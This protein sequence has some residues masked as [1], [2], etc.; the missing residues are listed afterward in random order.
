MSH[1]NHHNGYIFRSHNSNSNSD[2]M[3]ISNDSNLTNKPLPAENNFLND[4]CEEADQLINISSSSKLSNLKE[5]IIRKDYIIRE[6]KKRTCL[7][8]L[9]KDTN[10][11][12]NILDISDTPLSTNVHQLLFGILEI[13]Y[14]RSRFN[15]ELSCQI[16]LDNIFQPTDFVQ[17]PSFF[18]EGE[19]LFFTLWKLY[20]TVDNFFLCYDCGKPSSDN[21]LNYNQNDLDEETLQKYNNIKNRCCS[22]TIEVLLSFACSKDI[23]K[24][25]LKCGICQSII[26]KFLK[27]KCGHIFHR[28]CL[29]EYILCPVSTCGFPLNINLLHGQHLHDDEDNNNEDDNNDEGED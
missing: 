3:I 1:Y 21:I 16:I 28:R 27:L 19:N 4:Q 9:T 29:R 11:S 15:I 8:R 12:K 23:V 13:T 25:D 2:D 7:L 26:G 6:L 10:F 24:T 18:A 20:K 5:L 17:R 22:C 14:E